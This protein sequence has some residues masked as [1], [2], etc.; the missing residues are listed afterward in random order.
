[1]FFK[2]YFWVLII[3]IIIIVGGMLFINNTSSSEITD[4]QKNSKE[5][6]FEQEQKLFSFERL[7]RN[8]FDQFATIISVD[9]EIILLPVQFKKQENRVTCE[10]AALR[11]S[12]NYLGIDIT[13]NDLIQNMVFNAT[14]PRSMVNEWGDPQLGF[15]GDING[16]IFLGTGYGVYN[17]PIKTLAEKYTDAEILEEPTLAKV[18]ELTQKGTPVIVWGLLSSKYSTYWSSYEGNLIKAYPGEHARIVMGYTGDINNP[19]SIILM[20]PLYGKVRME[21]GKFLEE[22]GML[23]NMTVAVGI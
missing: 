5:Y 21:T 17:E 6:F 12:L 19:K 20:D 14:E 13:E 8:L 15:V 18:L 4:H 11:M 23:N 16:S 22:W 9:A 2:K 10:I 1:M 3:L 7:S